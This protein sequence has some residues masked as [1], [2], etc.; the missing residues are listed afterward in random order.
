MRKKII[1]TLIAFAIT[2]VWTILMLRVMYAA[3]GRAANTDH[4]KHRPYGLIHCTIL[5]LMCICT[6]PALFI[7]IYERFNKDD[8][9]SFKYI[10]AAIFSAVSAFFSYYLIGIMAITSHLYEQSVIIAIIISVIFPTVFIWLR[11]RYSNINN[12]KAVKIKNEINASSTANFT[13]VLAMTLSMIVYY[14][15]PGTEDFSEGIYRPIREIPPVVP[16]ILYIV[17]AVVGGIVFLSAYESRREGKGVIKYVQWLFSQFIVLLFIFNLMDA[18]YYI[19]FPANARRAALFMI[20]SLIPVIICLISELTDKSIT[21][22]IVAGIRKLLE[23]PRGDMVKAEKTGEIKKQAKSLLGGKIFA[24]G[25]LMM[26]LAEIIYGALNGFATFTL[27]GGILVSGPIAYGLAKTEM[28]VVTGKKEQADL[29][30]LFSGFSENFTQTIV[31]K[32]LQSI[33]LSLWSLL[34]IIP[35]VLKSYSYSMSFY[36]QQQAENK[37]WRY[38]LDE[39]MR[40]MYGNR[41]R[42]FLLDLSFIGWYILGS[43]CLGI[44]VLFVMPYHK[45]ARAVFFNSLLLADKKIKEERLNNE[46]ELTISDENNISTQS[47]M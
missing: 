5:N 41:F 7:W 38:A 2:C 31:L 44:G 6:L 21:K 12:E 22:S 33:F 20:F 32:L 26:M 43:M 39:S 28:N 14:T 29:A 19:D 37:N 24:G 9:S 34:F 42:L 25:W 46:T 27:I 45:T 30:D 10:F 8:T 15:L 35:G 13:S 23:K 17:T 36:I 4:V 3:A 18:N 11:G 16:N 40:L 47:V 1:G